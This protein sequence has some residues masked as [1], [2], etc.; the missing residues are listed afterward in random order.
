[1]TLAHR[2]SRSLIRI[3]HRP[4]ETILLFSGA[5]TAVPDDKLWIDAFKA[6][7]AF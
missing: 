6:R 2:I 5:S 3:H 4:P 1:M 7:L